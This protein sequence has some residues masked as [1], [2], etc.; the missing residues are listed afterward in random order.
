MSSAEF[1]LV[2]NRPFQVVLVHKLVSNM[3]NYNGQKAG[4]TTL[5]YTISTPH[6]SFVDSIEQKLDSSKV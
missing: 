5:R 4:C 1:F 6:P 3:T 2:G